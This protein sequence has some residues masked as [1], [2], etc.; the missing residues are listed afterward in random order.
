VGRI[1]GFLVT[2]D[3]RYTV[4][5]GT[6]APDQAHWLDRPIRCQGTA[7]FNLQMDAD[8][9]ISNCP[10]LDVPLEPMGPPYICGA[11]NHFERMGQQLRRFVLEH[12]RPGSQP[13]PI[14]LSGPCG[15]DN[16]AVTERLRQILDEA[17]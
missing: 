11:V 3:E 17:Q 7:N 1:S 2:G 6:M 9:I 4:A 8:L 10:D 13:N 16:Q 12:V 15:A 5:V 14:Q